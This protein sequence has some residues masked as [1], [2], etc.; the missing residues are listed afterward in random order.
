MLELLSAGSA[1]C[2]QVRLKKSMGATDTKARFA[3]FS[4][5]LKA[6][7]FAI[8]CLILRSSHVVAAVLLGENT[9]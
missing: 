3:R 1:Q 4:L 2:W 8:V 6:Y 7:I 9:R 5:R